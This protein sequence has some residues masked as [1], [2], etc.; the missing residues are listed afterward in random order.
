M[1]FHSITR[2]LENKHFPDKVPPKDPANDNKTS[3]DVEKELETELRDALVILLKED[4]P[5]LFADILL[6]E[7]HQ[8]IEMLELV[9]QE[10]DK[11]IKHLRAKVNFSKAVT[12]KDNLK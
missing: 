2:A 11:T 4:I 9:T 8:A 10:H 12:G 7:D 1:G 3:E 6:L 5:N